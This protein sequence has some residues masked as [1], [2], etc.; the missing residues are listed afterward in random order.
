M[1]KKIVLLFGTFDGIHAGH[2][3]LF[4][5][6]SAFGNSIQVIVAR[7]ATVQQVKNRPPLYAEQER[8]AALQREPYITHA[9]L[10]SLGDKYAALL[11]IQ[12]AVIALGYY[13]EAFTERLQTYVSEHLPSTQIVRLQPFYPEQFSSTIINNR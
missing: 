1:T 4:A 6:A 10:G 2:R 5:Q 11:L 12:P 8:L 7:D 3:N 9:Q 13:Q